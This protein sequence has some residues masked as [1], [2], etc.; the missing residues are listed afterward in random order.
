MN[1]RMNREIA[2]GVLKLIESELSFRGFI[3]RAISHIA[4]FLVV[5]SGAFADEANFEPLAIIDD[6]VAISKAQEG[7]LQGASMEVDI[8]AE[9]PTLH[10]SGRLHA[11]RRIS[12]LGRRITYDALRF[13]GDRSIKNDVIAR[14]LTAESEALKSEPA[15][16]AVTPANYK[17]KYKG[18]IEKEGRSVH[19]FHVTPRKKKAGLFVGDLWLDPE[20]HL[21]VRES[22][23]LVKSPSLFLRKVEFV[24]DYRIEQGVAIPTRIQSSVDTRLVGKANLSVAFGAVSLSIPAGDS[25]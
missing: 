12:S 3:L 6:Y 11:L 24:R 2:C 25:E 15:T 8:E 7:R 9:V 17:F 20:T 23:R 4:L 13:E 22:G 16:L 1:R 5:C 14:Y 18:L 10:K 19:A 21:A